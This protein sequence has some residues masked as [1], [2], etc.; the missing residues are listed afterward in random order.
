VKD[1]D[2][3]GPGR[4]GHDADREN[5]GDT[6]KKTFAA[7]LSP[8]LLALKYLR[9]KIQPNAHGNPIRPE[10]RPSNPDISVRFHWQG[11]TG[12]AV[13]ICC[14]PAIT[15]PMDPSGSARRVKSWLRFSDQLPG[16]LG[17]MAAIAN[18]QSNTLVFYGMTQHV[19]KIL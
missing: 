15:K 8:P 2:L 3:T 17:A 18:H 13:I 7:H 19:D 11:I 16:A 10:D 1:F 4:R 6:S 12:D 5:G 14:E 9:K